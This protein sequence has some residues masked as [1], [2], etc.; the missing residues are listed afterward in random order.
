MRC[1]ANI[2]QYLSETLDMLLILVIIMCRIEI[3][4]SLYLTEV[5]EI[6]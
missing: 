4:N 5:V 3:D 1:V 6:S 2:A